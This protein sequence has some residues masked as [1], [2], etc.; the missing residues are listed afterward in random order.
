MRH[1]YIAGPYFAAVAAF[2]GLF[3][4]AL[5]GIYTF[6][7]QDHVNASLCQNVVEN[8]EADRI[9]WLTLRQLILP[10]LESEEARNATTRLID[11]VLRPIPSLECV[12]N[13][14]IP[15]EG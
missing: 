14:P 12:D 13:K 9:Q 8:R 11:G 7:Q 1:V 3:L 10:T 6:R 15:K 4:F 2:L 5:A